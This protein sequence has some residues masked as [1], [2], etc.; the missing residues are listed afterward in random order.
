MRG[1]FFQRLGCAITV[2]FI[3]LLTIISLVYWGAD[4]HPMMG[5]PMR[6][7]P[8]LVRAFWPVL[9]LAI[10][11]GFFLIGRALRR[12]AAPVGDMLDA[13]GKVADGDYAVRVKEEGPSE[14]R[15]LAQ[16]FNSMVGRLQTNDTQRRNLLADISH[17]LRTP[18]TIIQGNLEGML[19]GIYP[20]DTRTIQSA[21]EETHTL[22]RI[23]DDLRTLA[24]VESGALKLQLEQVDPGELVEEVAASY[25]SQ[26]QGKGVLLEVKLEPDLP[27]IE[28]DSTRIHEVLSN[29]L[30]N[31]LRHTPVG[32]KITIACNNAQGTAKRLEITV[33]DTGTGIPADQLPHIFDR[34]YKSSDSTGSGLGL[35][36]SKSLI[37]AHN[38]EITAESEPGRGTTITIRLPV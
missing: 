28:A 38:G 32:G 25:R 17:E 23:I 35:A 37:S 33:K 3:A 20:T 1:R 2:L 21:L 8:F 22:E 16:A 9:F 30:V 10:L 12:A 5:G 27:Q 26:A 29:L 31:S 15:A 18:L 6:G 13:A 19:D 34:F 14:V 36:I 24:V 7:D 4:R 11:F